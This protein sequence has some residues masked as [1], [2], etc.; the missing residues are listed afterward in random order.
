[1]GQPRWSVYLVRCGA[2]ALYTGIATDVPRRL[3]EHRHARGK[4]AKYLRGRGPLRLVFEKKIGAKGLALSVESRI[5][6]L[7]KAR[8]EALIEQDHF[9]NEIISRARKG[10]VVPTLSSTNRGRS[11]IVVPKTLSLREAHRPDHNH[12]KECDR[13]RGPVMNDI[14]ASPSREAHTARLAAEARSACPSAVNGA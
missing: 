4:G 6:K 14:S 11:N 7:P 5:K 9:I 12:L 8:K 13:G 2:G 1:M 10:A 3:A